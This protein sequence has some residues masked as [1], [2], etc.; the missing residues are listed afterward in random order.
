M[1]DLPTG[2]LTLVFTDMEGSTRHAQRLGDRYP[3]LLRTHRDLLRAAFDSHEGV[4]VDMHGDASFYVFSR[5]SGA[6]AA[7]VEVQK[8]LAAQTWPG[9]VPLRVRIGLH[10]GEPMRTASGYAG[11]D[12]HRAARICAV[13]H[14]GQVLMSEPVSKLVDHRLPEAVRLRDLGEHRLKDLPR[15]ERLYQLDIG[16]LPDEFPPLRSLD[17]RPNNLP[18]PLTPLI[19]REREIEALV[20]LLRREDVRLVTLTG[21]GGTGKT[22]LA[23]RVASDVLHDF[24][25]GAFF[26][27]LGSITDPSLVPTAIAQT[28]D[29][30]PD[31]RPPLELLK[32]ELR[33][34]QLLLVLD[35]FEQILDAALT[36]AE[37]LSSLPGLRVLVTSRAPLRLSGEREILVPPLG[38]PESSQPPDA[39]VLAQYPA[40][41]LFVERAAA[42]KGDFA[43][44]DENAATVAGICTRLDGLPLAIELAAA[45]IK[46]FSPQALLGRLARRLDLLTG[47]P[48]DLPARQQT[49]RD[50]LAWS[51]ALLTPEE[52]TLFRR[53]GVFA[54][55]C[56]LDAVEAVCNTERDLG[57][58][59]LEGV[60]SLVDKS[61]L[62]RKE[63]IAGDARFWMLETIHE[64]ALDRL[65][66]SGEGA[67]LRAKHAK[68]YMAL[69]QT[70][71][72]IFRRAADPRLEHLAAEQ[73]NMRAA[74]H[75]TVV[76]G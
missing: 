33:G 68:H 63:G 50:T 64:F 5:A 18:T 57:I 11:L 73:D 71:G 60:T 59:V 34:K 69:V 22:R 45:R 24:G 4:E 19:G 37:L 66:S 76:K 23:T 7:A 72:S 13:G 54:G 25:D 52:Q 35:N 65:A 10:L 32:T 42:V 67:A 61:L 12:V 70:A 46:V 26:V 41:A 15:P 28:L 9:D 47:G 39:N 48:R 2:T 75:W 44:S 20:A 74:L 6:V 17:T 53:L 49:L 1:R 36:V 8:A 62:V 14:G 27:A 58:E 29:L 38:L 56:T 3:Q 43:L 40:I 30:R 55:G 51:H 16:G 31:S 21:P